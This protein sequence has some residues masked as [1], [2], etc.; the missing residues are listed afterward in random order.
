MA[1]GGRYHPIWSLALGLPL[2]GAAIFLYAAGNGIFSIAKG[3][4]PLALFGPDRYGSIMGRLA[5][6]G[7]IAQ[8]VAPTMGAVLL[9]AVGADVTL[10][11]LALLA[12]VNI[13]LVIFLWNGVER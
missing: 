11:V 13:A 3:A 7:L 4:L 2:V 6:P 1:S 9:F 12:L 5:R 10:N 8:A